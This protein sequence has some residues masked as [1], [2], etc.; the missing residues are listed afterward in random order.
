MTTPNSNN[1][2]LFDLDGSLADYDGQMKKD[3]ELLRDPN[4][5]T[6]IYEDLH[7]AEENWPSIKNRMKLIKSVP[8]W[9]LNLPVIEPGRIVFNIAKEIGFQCEI[10]TKGPKSNPMAWKEKLEWVH[11]NLGDDVDV[12]ITANKSRVYGKVLFDD[13]PPFMQGWLEHRPRG[14]GIM[15]CNNNNKD[16][17][18]PN[19][20]KYD[21]NNL[22]QIKEA[23]INAFNRQVT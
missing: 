17:S 8:G 21:G 19:V 23:L 16:Y 3:L 22:E 11:K 6:G 20:I 14:L 7:G 9:W 18:H 4:E 15:L 2:A 13:Y 5:Q 1:V 10:L 12:H